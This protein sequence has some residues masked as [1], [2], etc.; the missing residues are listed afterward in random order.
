MS[1]IYNPSKKQ[2]AVWLFDC[3][4]GN[5][6]GDPIR[7]NLPRIDL[8]ANRGIVTDVCLKRHIRN[9]LEEAGKDVNPERNKLLIQENTVINDIIKRAYTACELSTV[10]RKTTIEEQQQSL[11]WLLDNFIDLRLFGGVLSTGDL[12]AGQYNGP[13]Q[14]T[15]AQSIDPIYPEIVSITRCAATNNVEGK[16]NKTF[17]KKAYIPYGLYKAHV[18]YSPCRDTYKKVTEEDLRLL[19]GAIANCFEINLSAAKGMLATKGL[20]IYT[21]KNRLGNYPLHKLFDNVTVVKTVEAIPVKFDDYTVKV[22][23]DYPKD[24]VTCTEVV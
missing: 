1:V 6:N 4:M 17:G 23:T 14:V 8:V 7:N 20:W 15:F 3:T 16:D 5:P 10:K 19:W 24:L 9:Y 12:K 2:S 21:H 13:V 11:L 18:V 22:K